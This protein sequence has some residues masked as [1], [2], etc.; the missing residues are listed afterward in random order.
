M[1]K[2]VEVISADMTRLTES[3]LES[4]SVRLYSR[5]GHFTKGELIP[6]YFLLIYGCGDESEYNNFLFGLKD[7]IRKSSRPFAFIDTPLDG[8]D[9]RER[10]SFA[11]VGQGSTAS[12]IS[13]LCSALEIK[14]DPDRTA[15]AQKALGDMLSLSSTDIFEAGLTLVHKLNEVA[16]AI[17]T[18]AS[19][20]IPIIMYYGN[21]S[22]QDVFFLC[23]AQRC[24]F[25]VVCISPD[26]SCVIN[27]E[28][29]PFADR[30]QKEQLADS[31]AVMTFPEKMVKSKIATAAYNAERE[32]DTALYGGDTIFRDRQF[33]KMDSAVLRT[34]LDEVFILWDQP[35]KF[36]SGFA[37]RGDRVTVPTIF[38]KI[39]GVF[40]GNLRAYWKKAE[41]LITPQSIYVIKAP[42]YKKPHGNLLAS[43]MKYVN[44]SRIDVSA[45]IRSPL[46][47]YGFLPE[48]LQ[49]L[50]FEKMQAVI[51]DG[52]LELDSPQ[53][54][55][56]Y[57]L[58]TGLNLDRAVIRRLREY[59][60]TKDI[61]KF[62][63]ADA[64]EEPFSKLECTQLL[65]LSYLGFDVLILSPSGYRDIEAYVSDDA[66]ETHNLSEFKYNVSVPRFKIP[67]EAKYRKQ[68]NSLLK[69][70]FKKGR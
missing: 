49:E 3:L 58:H 63:V 30:L 53:E 21:P 46:N 5:G 59:D 67:D 39:N 61:P 12:V 29:C 66:F 22:A 19:D 4:H 28:R 2:P 69:N 62:I 65:L 38:A 31:R 60:F 56:G 27:F 50:I 45:L 51:D 36:R 9:S 55:A 35:A 33:E 13:G 18:G 11:S 34:T 32:L 37:V 23:F 17:D 64:I 43:Y 10:L 70:I 24:G 14:N 6:V 68:K 48:S 54:A 20:E 25:D 16:N 40:K 8:P 52:M 26:K 42:S 44:G 47:Q 15:L 1:Y 7:E 41:E 57:V